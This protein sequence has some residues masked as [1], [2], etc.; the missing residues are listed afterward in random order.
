M[1]SLLEQFVVNVS[2]K[3][4]IIFN[5][6]FLLDPW[7]RQKLILAIIFILGAIGFVPAAAPSSSLLGR[8]P[9]VSCVALIALLETLL[10][11]LS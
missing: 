7:W 1:S 9:H 3:G 10:R 5:L 2:L 11:F 6:V 4:P 8:A